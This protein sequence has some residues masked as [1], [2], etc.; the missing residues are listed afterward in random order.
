MRGP[1]EF[2]YLMSAAIPAPTAP[3]QR[4]APHTIEILEWLGYSQVEMDEL[5]TQGVVYWP[6][7][8]YRWNV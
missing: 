3:S 2:S 4:T 6:D 5:K 1:G 7:D 8:D